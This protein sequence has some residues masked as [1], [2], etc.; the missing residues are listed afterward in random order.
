MDQQPPEIETPDRPRLRLVWSNP[1]PPR[2]RPQPVN[3]ALAI[4]R[5]LTGQDGLSEDEFLELFSGRSGA[6]H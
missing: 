5:H 6:R 2:P 4:E 1:N 3:L